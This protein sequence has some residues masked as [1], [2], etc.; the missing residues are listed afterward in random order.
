MKHFISLPPLSFLFFQNQ[1]ARSQLQYWKCFALSLS[2]CTRAPRQNKNVKRRLE[3]SSRKLSRRQTK[4]RRK[5]E[6]QPRRSDLWRM[7]FQKKKREH[8]KWRRWSNLLQEHSSEMFH[9]D[10]GTCFQLEKSRGMP[11]T[12]NLPFIQQILIEHVLRAWHCSRKLG[13]MNGGRDQSDASTSPGT[14]KI[15]SKPPEAGGGAWTRFFLRTFRRNQPQ[16]HL[17]LGLLASKTVRE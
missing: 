3:K 15:A 16:G 10:E 5:L 11:S 8:M 4:E 13:S 2:V 1:R 6:N 14:S 12:M 9:Q 17:D 7:V